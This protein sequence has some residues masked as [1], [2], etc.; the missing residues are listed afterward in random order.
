MRA[1]KIPICGS[2]ADG[3]RWYA[4]PSVHA[5]WALIAAS[6]GVLACAGTAMADV[7]FRHGGQASVLGTYTKLRREQLPSGNSMTQDIKSGTLR[8][9]PHA[10]ATLYLENGDS[11]DARWELR[12]QFDRIDGSDETTLNNYRGWLRYASSQYEVRFGLQ[13]LN[14]GP[15]RVLRP[16]RWFDSIDPTDPLQI[17]EGVKGALGRYFFSG[18]TNLWFWGLLGNDELKGHELPGYLTPEDEPEWGMR[19]QMLALGGEVA[20]TYHR[21]QVEEVGAGGEQGQEDRLGLDAV[22]DVGVGLWLEGYISRM[23]F[24]NDDNL[25]DRQAMAGVDYT[26]ESGTRILGEHSVRYLGED[27]D[28]GERVANLSA[29]HLEHPVNLL[30]QLQVTVFF[31]WLDDEPSVSLTWLRSYDEFQV[32]LKVFQGNEEKAVDRARFHERRS[33]IQARITYFY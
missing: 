16:L 24:E 32:E 18:N 31:D 6:F 4:V 9:L 8:Y 29:F 17:T 30:D 27:A 22:W 21:R 7:Q 23:R 11:I 5:R 1:R 13:Q 2:A 26:L 25:W 15:A 3:C 33:G 28:G 10:D 12:G 14:F 20:T 19:Y